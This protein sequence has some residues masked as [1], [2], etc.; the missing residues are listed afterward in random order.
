VPFQQ[1][2]GT[3]V[4]WCVEGLLDHQRRGDDE[5]MST[6]T[7]TVGKHR[8]VLAHC[9]AFIA[10]LAVIPAIASAKAGNLDPSFGRQGKLV[11]ATSGE[12]GDKGSGVELSMGPVS[13]GKLVVAGG[14]EVRKLLASG[15]PDQSFGGDGRVGL[16]VDPGTAFLLAGVAVDSQGRVLVA[17]T[18]ESRT[19]SSTPA[20]SGFNENAVGPRPQWATVYRFLPD[21]SLD[22]SF[23]DGGI[24]KT[25]F[26]LPRPI[27]PGPY[28]ATYPSEA[29]GVTAI[30][31]DDSDRPLV[32]GFFIRHVGQCRLEGP[33]TYTGQAYVARLTSN[34]SM[35]P[36]FGDKGAISDP[37]MEFPSQL[38][39]GTVDGIAY[40]G[41]S[42]MRCVTPTSPSSSVLVDGDF[43]LVKLSDNASF[44]QGFGTEGRRW[45][46]DVEIIALASDHDGVITLV[47][48]GD[49][50]RDPDTQIVRRL[51]PD[52]SRDRSFGQNGAVSPRIIRRVEATDLAVDSRGRTLLAGTTQ[53]VIT[54]VQSFVV[55]RLNNSG[56]A[57]RRF[58]REGRR[59]TTFGRRSNAEAEQLA[60]DGRR[61]IVVGGPVTAPRLATGHGFAFARYLS[62]R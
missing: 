54:G 32:A 23:G 25:Y 47:A 59:I 61:R 27:G 3:S 44:D 48:R 43:S 9:L 38:E 14:G 10:V 18:T 35:D 40:S 56:R 36:S 42:P 52:G 12:Q 15:R 1:T 45:Q 55:A 46:P 4:V 2:P 58:G 22:P 28:S 16:S 8:A 13:E 33:M 62:G 11:I 17:G 53:G 41:A 50:Q 31:I 24:I 30:A 34:G 57:D 21:G 60:I 26:G 49:K 5:S 37:Q 7:M 29:V 6:S 51:L 19:V 20:P 39:T